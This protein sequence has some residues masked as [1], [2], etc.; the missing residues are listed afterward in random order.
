MK[1]W[2]RNRSFEEA[3]GQLFM[4]GIPGPHFSGEAAFLLKKIRAG[5][6]ILFKRNFQDPYQLANLP[7]PADHGPGSS[8]P[9]ALYF[10]RPGGG[11]GVAVGTALYPT[12]GAGRSGG[13]QD[14]RRTFPTMPG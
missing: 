9:A 12:T 8:I 1:D 5:G 13:R 3:L 11:P 2:M 7:A 14:A 10:H 6:I 4:V